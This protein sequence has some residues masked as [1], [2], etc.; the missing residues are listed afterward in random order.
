MRRDLLREDTPSP[1]GDESSSDP[2][3]VVG[4]PPPARRH[5]SL[6]DLFRAPPDSSREEGLLD[7]GRD[8]AGREARARE[9]ALGQTTRRTRPHDASPRVPEVVVSYESDPGDGGRR[10]ARTRVLEQDGDN[11]HSVDG[12]FSRGGASHLGSHWND[13]GNFYFEKQRRKCLVPSLVATGRDAGRSMVKVRGRGWLKLLGHDAFTSLIEMHWF[14]LTTLVVGTHFATFV[15]FALFWLIVNQSSNSCLG[16]FDDGGFNAALIFSVA[17]QTT[18]GYGTRFVK[19]ECRLGAALLFIQIIVGVFVNALSLG[20]IFARITDPKHRARSIFVSD[21]ACVATRDGELKFMFRVADARDRKVIAPAVRACLYSWSGRTTSEGERLPVSAQPLRI[22]KLDPLMLLPITIEHVIDETSPLFGHT[23]DSINACGAEIVVALEGCVDATGLSFSARQSYLPSEI[24]W[25]HTFRRIIRRAP[26]GSTRHE[27]ALARFHELEPQEMLES[28]TV[29]KR[30]GVSF[31]LGGRALLTAQQMCEATIE[32]ARGGGENIVPFP[33]IG[34]N[35]LALSDS[36][37]IDDSMT[38]ATFRVGDT[39]SPWGCQFA[40]VVAKAS[41]H[42]WFAKSDGATTHECFELPL[43]FSGGGGP[44]ALPGGA[45]L[46]LWAPALVDHDMTA[47]E[48]PR[49]EKKTSSELDVDPESRTRRNA[50]KTS[51]LLRAFSMD[52]ERRNVSL[53]LSARDAVVVVCV[54]GTCAVDGTP[55]TRRRCY[56]AGDILPRRRFVE[57]T[58][59]PSRRAMWTEPR[60][61]FTQFHNSVA[62]EKERRV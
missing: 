14:F 41:L 6:E 1:A 51:P 18:L 3:L 35:T 47:V 25:G 2:V 8:A 37:V 59:P 48:S 50:K 33:A 31:Q 9:R 15:L 53:L 39:R 11:D 62:V 44:S 34:A 26:S 16:G 32:A 24:L 28:P 57:I 52:A 4:E 61:D 21:A 38:T 19:S 46:D 23:H 58:S 13:R 20:V 42:V 36:I 22:S 54:S 12:D 43:S 49:I 7:V 30:R 29:L 40:D 45:S 5:S 56:S 17:T 27:V 10:H 60:V 55:R